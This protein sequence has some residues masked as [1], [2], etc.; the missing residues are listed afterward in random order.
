VI[1][2]C[3]SDACLQGTRPCPTPEACHIAP[4]ERRTFEPDYG[5]DGIP[6]ARARA[7]RRTRNFVLSAIAIAA[8]VIFSARLVL[9]AYFPGAFE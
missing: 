8:V 3:S 1:P 6:E 2:H 7:A 4:V 9:R 5:I